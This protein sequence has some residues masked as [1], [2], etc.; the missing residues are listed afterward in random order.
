MG[1]SGCEPTRI[2]P[3]ELRPA[4][5][6]SYDAMCDGGLDKKPFLVRKRDWGAR[7]FERHFSKSLQPGTGS[8]IGCDDGRRLP[9]DHDEA[10]SEKAPLTASAASVWHAPQPL[11]ATRTAGPCTD[12]LLTRREQ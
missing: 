2:R 12:L 4:N 9:A 3:A 10:Q 1:A 11:D 6:E 7:S 8:R 5:V